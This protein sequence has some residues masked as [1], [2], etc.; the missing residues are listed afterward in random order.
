[1]IPSLRSGISILLFLI[2]GFND[3]LEFKNVSFHYDDSDEP[4]LKQVNLSVT[5]GNVIALVGSSGAG[6]TTLV[7]LIPRFYDPTGGTIELDGVD[8]KNVRIEDLRKLMGIVT[9]E[10][11][12]FNESVRSNIAYGLDVVRKRN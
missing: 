10:T 12:L 6:K 2:T 1:L 4:V 3:S 11:V 8:I 5:K 9:Q 7:D